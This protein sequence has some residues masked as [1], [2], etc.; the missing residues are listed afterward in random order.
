MKTVWKWALVLLLKGGEGRGWKTR[1]R[2]RFDH[3]EVG[4]CYAGCVVDVG[5]PQGIILM[6]RRIVPADEEDEW[7]VAVE[8]GRGFGVDLFCGKIRRV[9]EIAHS[10]KRQV[11]RHSLGWKAQE[12]FQ[13]GVE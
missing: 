10:G 5:L 2:A 12:M 7:L 3:A 1:T 11:T 13:N 8:D 4:S 9:S 6:G